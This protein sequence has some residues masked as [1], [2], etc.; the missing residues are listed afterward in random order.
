MDNKS[1]EILQQLSQLVESNNFQQ[2]CNGFLDQYCDEFLEKTQSDV[3]P[4]ENLHRWHGYHQEYQQMVDQE[5]D[6]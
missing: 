3:N 1:K 4:D 6:N 5:V 2:R